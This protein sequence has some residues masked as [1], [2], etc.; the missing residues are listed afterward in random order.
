MIYSLFACSLLRGDILIINI[1]NL[2]K[3]QG[4]TRYWLAKQ[5]NVTYPNL[6]ALADNKTQSVKFEIIEKICFALN[7]TPNEILLLSSPDNNI[8]TD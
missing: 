1:D 7:C 2:L 5:I 8:E 6:C 4:K 3:K